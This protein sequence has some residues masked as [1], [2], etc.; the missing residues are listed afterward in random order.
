MFSLSLGQQSGQ[1]V[2]T[3]L[4]SMGLAGGLGVTATPAMTDFIDKAEL[5]SITH[6]HSALSSSLK[7]NRLLATSNTITIE[8][9]KVLLKNGYPLAKTTE[10]EKMASFGTQQLVDNANNTVTVWSLYESYCFIYTESIESNVN[11]NTISPAKLSSVSVSTT[12]TC[13][14]L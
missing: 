5:A 10:L 12:S 11:G 2:P 8:G 14:P 7:I 9:E 4:L 6:A 13:T 1:I 3:M